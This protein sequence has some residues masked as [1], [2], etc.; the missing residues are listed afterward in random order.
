MPSLT[1]TT[2][3]PCFPQSKQRWLKQGFVLMWGLAGIHTV[4][5]LW[6]LH[7]HWKAT[8]PTGLLLIFPLR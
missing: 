2:V 6:L 5:T 4:R 7:M 8:G 1:S 3:V